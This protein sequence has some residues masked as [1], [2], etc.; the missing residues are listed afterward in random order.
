MPRIWISNPLNGKYINANGAP[1]NP[2]KK[3]PQVGQP[4]PNAPII[5]PKNPNTP[6][7]FALINENLNT[8]KEKYI[9]NRIEIIVINKMLK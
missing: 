7:F 1:I 2:N 4:T 8:T 5:P 6:P 9:P 3:A